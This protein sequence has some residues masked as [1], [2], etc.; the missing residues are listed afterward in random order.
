M[1]FSD[2]AIKDICERSL[3]N[4]E[5][6]LAAKEKGESIYEV[7]QLVNSFLSLV[8]LWKQKYFPELCDI[9]IPTDWPQATHLQCNVGNLLNKM[10]NAICHN[11]LEFQSDQY[12]QYLR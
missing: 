10:R 3:T 7:T 9:A 12:R 8:I 11:H 1:E 5:F 6:M 4:L 2:E